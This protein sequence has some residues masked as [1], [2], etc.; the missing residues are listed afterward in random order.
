MSEPFITRVTINPIMNPE[1][2]D[3]MARIP[4]GY[5]ATKLVEL[6]AYGLQVLQQGQR[7]GTI[8]LAIPSQARQ[9]VDLPAPSRSDPAPAHYAHAPSHGSLQTGAAEMAA[10]P[11][12]R[13]NDIQRPTQLE[14]V[15]VSQS[16]STSQN[17]V[18]PATAVYGG[19]SPQRLVRGNISI[20]DIS[21]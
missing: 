4:K 2:Y 9:I 14:D 19:S 6:A 15:K 17:A 5:K 16:S 1:L 18:K 3:E 10:A 8:T 20:D 11:I 13:P 7:S 12:N 21:G